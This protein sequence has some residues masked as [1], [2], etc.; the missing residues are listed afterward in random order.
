MLFAGGCDNDEPKIRTND[1]VLS[2]NDIDISYPKVH[3]KY[4]FELLITNR[5]DYY[6]DSFILKN[7]P[8]AR[9][10][11]CDDKVDESAWNKPVI[12][13]CVAPNSTD[14]IYVSIRKVTFCQNLKNCC[15]RYSTPKNIGG[16]CS[17]GD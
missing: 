5:S 11:S 9:G 13:A 6:L 2:W 10:E 16:Y 1:A 15:I 7:R 3:N 12:Y 4:N 8:K 14:R 17:R